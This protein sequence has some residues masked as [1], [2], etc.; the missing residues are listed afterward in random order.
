MKTHLAALL[1]S[2]AMV[3]PTAAQPLPL[4]AGIQ[5]DQPTDGQPW[6]VTAY[7]EN[8]GGFLKRNNVED[9]HYTNGIAITIAGQTDFADRI[10]EFVPFGHD[11]DRTALGLVAGQLMFTPENISTT[12]LVP[13]D[14]PYAGYLY[15]GAY[16]QRA[17]NHTL[18]HIEL[19]LGMTGPSSQAASLQD[20]VHESFNSKLPRGWDHQLRDEPQAQLFLRRKW[21]VNLT[22][23]D[24]GEQGFQTQFIPQVGAAVGTVH[25]HL[26][27]AATI[28][29]GW[30]L[31]DDFGPGRI[32]DI[33]SAVGQPRPGW[34][35]YGFARTTG[36]LVEHNV[37]LAGNNFHSSHSVD[38]KPL[39]GEV[40]AGLAAGY[41]GDQW[42]GQFGYSQ[43]IVSE[44]FDEQ[45]G[46]DEFAT[47]NVSLTGWF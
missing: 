14:R 20:S 32:A 13:D 19:N 2:L 11:M 39:V 36:R 8:D 5:L 12:Q 34:F 18:D 47:L 22:P 29:F 3:A 17:S 10:A 30:N 21:R 15:G 42:A 16:W 45:D 35:I 23:T 7:W 9:K 1:S 40:S 31:P 6:T 43:T 25:R 44:E 33:P 28:R 4:A 41:R 37:F 26:E 27:A 38:E 46:S 24:P